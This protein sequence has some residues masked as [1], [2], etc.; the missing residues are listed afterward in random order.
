[1]RFALA[2]LLFL[3]LAGPAG[4]F[5][6]L[7]IDFNYPAFRGDFYVCGSVTFPPGAVAS[8]ENLRV[9]T[10]SPAREVAAKKRVTDTWPD[11]SVLSMEVTFE[12][13][14]ERRREYRIAYGPDVKGKKIIAEAAVLPSIPFSLG[15][16]PLTT[17]NVNLD[18]GQLNVT[19][20]RSPGIHYYWHMIPIVF[21]SALAVI[22]SR[23]A[24]RPER[25]A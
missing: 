21:I 11:G 18:V 24:G 6:E 13:N 8:P 3:A 15:G 2:T 19:V 20:D 25:R 10:V 16:A 17:E 9:S 22:R 14:G 23:R 4:A 5:E 7:S 1:M 12:A